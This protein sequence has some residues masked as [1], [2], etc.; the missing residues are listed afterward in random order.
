MSR[1]MIAMLVAAAGLSVAGVCTE[2]MAR[3][4]GGHGGGLGSMHSTFNPLIQEMIPRITPQ[5]NNPGT[6]LV[7]PGSG[8]GTGLR[9]SL[10]ALPPS[11]FSEAGGGREPNASLI[12]RKENSS[13][14]AMMRMDRLLDQKLGSEIC[15][16]C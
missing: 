15:R 6:P 12:P 1:N 16:G 4:G 14:A 10:P 9:D 2:A 3:G 7:L 8:H 11:A 13:D 5:F